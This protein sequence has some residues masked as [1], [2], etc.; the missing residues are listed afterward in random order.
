MTANEI[1][2]KYLNFFEAK[3]HKIIPSA[4]LLPE[5]DPTTLFTGSGM[6]P[7]VPYLLGET[8]PE[9]KRITDSQKCFRSSDIEEVGDNRH[10]TFFEML[11][12]WSLGDYFK[13]EQ[14]EWIFEFLTSK[15]LGLGLNPE[16]I[17]ISVYRGNK[18]I[19]ISKDKEAV[20]LWQKQFEKTGV[21]T[22][23]V[24]NVETS[25]IQNENERIFY[26]DEKENWW[27]RAG[28]P[29]KM[30]VGELGGPD[31]EMFWDLGEKLNL[32][33]NSEWKNQPCHPA[34][35][36]GRFVEIGNN[37]FM[38]YIKTENGFVELENKNIDFGGGLERFMVAVEDNSDIFACSIFN[39]IRKKLEEISGKKYSENEEETKSFRVI[40]DHLRGATFLIGDGAIPSNKDQGY[41]TRRLIRRAVRFAHGLGVEKN[42][43]KKI[44]E[45]VIGDYS[46]QYKN[47][48]EKRDFILEEIDKE[49]KKFRNT[50]KK[51][52]KEFKKYMVISSGWVP[53]DVDEN[54]LTSKDLLGGSA[55]KYMPREIFF[56]LYDTF[57]FP[58]EMIKEECKNRGIVF[59][60][61][62][63][64][65]FNE[66]LEKHKQLSKTASAGKFKGGLADSREETKK[67]HT[68]AHLMLAALRK[69][70]G[71]H[72][73]QKGS[74]ITAERLRFD[75]S[76]P[77]KLTDEQKIE[78][79]KLVNSAIKNKLP[80]V[81]E[82]M[83]LAKAKESGATGVFDS[84][85]SDRVKVYKV[86]ENNNIFSN[87]ICGG[88]H[89]DNTSEI[90]KTFKIKKEKS[91]GSGVRRIKAVLE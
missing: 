25:G 20:K 53:D 83:D 67:L 29:E 60:E 78:V 37:V 40:M 43:T 8:H 54:N 88:P 33:E 46:E 73:Q 31:S 19:G 70:L 79:E 69:V 15:E 55:N 74:N 30:P 80:I 10:T 35:D 71:D 39:N 49:E 62:E 77:E 82:E 59:E 64:R 52:L 87:E 16:R 50:L 84:R 11:G 4:S 91:S 5:N 45:V 14:I 51:G 57:G 44:A 58:L 12:N 56:R 63:E 42:F 38:Q 28:V 3:G 36:C 41:F 76:H 81:C 26:Y 24:D 47:L 66:D 2:Q 22:E 85:Y 72:V 1:R 75:F 90:K 18:N 7:M 17:Y 34:C 13:K 61:R 68:V 32:H 48:V 27:S 21:K 23:V 6:Q 9:G 86:G 89:V 65:E